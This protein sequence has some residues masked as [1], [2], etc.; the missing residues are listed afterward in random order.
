MLTRTIDTCKWLLMQ[1]T[2]KS[3]SL[4]NLLQCLH[5]QLV[6]I[7]CYI[8]RTINRCDLMLRRSN[9]IVLCFCRNTILPQ[10]LIELSHEMR[11]LILDHAEVLIIKLLSLWCRCTKQ[12]TSGQL[13]VKS[14]IELILVDQKVLLLWS[15]GGSYLRRCLTEEFQDTKCLLVN[16]IH[17]TKKWCLMIQR[18]ARI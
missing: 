4:C 12:C 9:L 7:G 2:C 11:N 17:G 6:L 5:Q 18:L 15:N 16:G 8:C 13:Q 1:Q 3:V 14:L 10:I